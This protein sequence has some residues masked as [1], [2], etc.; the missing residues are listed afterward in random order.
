L[1]GMS[2]VYAAGVRASLT[3]DVSGHVTVSYGE[4]AGVESPWTA[5]AGFS[6]RF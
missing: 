6:W 5:Q 3:E 1:S 4:G 2:G